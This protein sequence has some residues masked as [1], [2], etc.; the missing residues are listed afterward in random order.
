MSLIPVRLKS[1]SPST[2]PRLWE[3]GL[4]AITS[5]A[6]D[7]GRPLCATRILRCVSVSNAAGRRSSLSES[8]M[9]IMADR[10]G[11]PG[12]RLVRLTVWSTLNIKSLLWAWQGREGDCKDAL[13]YLMAIAQANHMYFIVWNVRISGRPSAAAMLGHVTGSP[14]VF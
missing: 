14:F 2:S 7:A 1:R 10:R 11:L 6:P 3:H 12:P 13:I 9:V 8:V 5:A 4:S